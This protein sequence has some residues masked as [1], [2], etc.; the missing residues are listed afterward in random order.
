MWSFDDWLKDKKQQGFHVPN[1]TF[2]MRNTQ[3][4]VE[5]DRMHKIEYNPFRSNYTER[6]IEDTNVLPTK[7]WPLSGVIA[8]TNQTHGFKPKIINQDP[9]KS[10]HQLMEEC[11]ESFPHS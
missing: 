11:F 7:L 6:E 3:E 5:Y 10:F 1:F 9:D 2:A 8:P 4:I